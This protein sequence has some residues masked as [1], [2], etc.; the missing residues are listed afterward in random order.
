MLPDPAAQ[1]APMSSDTPIEL[2][3]I[4]APPSTL[5][6][7]R[8]G[9]VLLSSNAGT[10]SEIARFVL[11]P[12]R[13]WVFLDIAGALA[14]FCDVW[15]ADFDGVKVAGESMGPRSEL[16]QWSVLVPPLPH[17]GMMTF[18]NSSPDGEA[19]VLKLRSLAVSR[20]RASHG[21]ESSDTILAV[22]DLDVRSATFG[23][24]PF[25]AV[26]D[27]QRAEHGAPFLDLLV[28]P[29]SQAAKRVLGRE[30]QAAFPEAARL[31]FIGR[32]L[33]TITECLPTIRRLDIAAD[34][35]SAREQL[36]TSSSPLVGL[37]NSGIAISDSLTIADSRHF[38]QDSRFR[39][40]SHRLVAPPGA[41]EVVRDWILSVG[42]R[43]TRPV[44]TVTLRNE[45]Y[46]ENWN[47]D[48][49]VWRQALASIDADAV[50]VPDSR[51]GARPAPDGPWTVFPF[52]GVEKQVAL[53][54]LATQNLAQYG[55]H[56]SVVLATTA[57]FVYWVPSSAVGGS[58]PA[59][60]VSS[61]GLGPEPTPQCLMPGQSIRL[62][63]PSAGT[64]REAALAA[65]RSA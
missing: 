37:D 15:F 44:V 40:G 54:E 18:V 32:L 2:C 57:P 52:P 29:E 30:F 16:S 27:Q 53:Y 45:R 17:G 22:Y 4:E 62:E 34:R 51:R 39:S 24:V 13:D 55:D 12:E 42:S 5:V 36:R 56:S 8:G 43:G 35:H 11:S 25:L 20:L 31:D 28:L 26:V 10:H 49:E 21:M 14:G 50:L 33:P 58:L 59:E 61:L 41:G 19:V 64:I 1:L 65:I 63:V 60:I 23:V 38:L 9:E 7:P 46:T 47:S 3:A 48:L 6:R